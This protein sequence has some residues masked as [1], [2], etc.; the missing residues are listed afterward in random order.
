MRAVG[1]SMDRWMVGLSG[2]WTRRM[3]LKGIETLG[4]WIRHQR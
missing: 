4:G 2:I 3:V 1:Q